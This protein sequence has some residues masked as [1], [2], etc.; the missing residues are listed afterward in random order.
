MVSRKTFIIDENIRLWELFVKGEDD[1]EACMHYRR[2]DYTA[3][4]D[5]T[6][7]KRFIQK[8]ADSILIYAD[9]VL[10]HELGSIHA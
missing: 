4:I 6:Q 8:T 3:H 10:K 9:V 1:R 7:K 5:Q 2:P